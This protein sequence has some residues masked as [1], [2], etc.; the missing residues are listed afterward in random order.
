[1][2]TTFQK[3]FSAGLNRGLSA[4]S[5]NVQAW[6]LTVINPCVKASF[7]FQVV[8]NSRDSSPSVRLK[9]LNGQDHFP[10]ERRSYLQVVRDSIVAS[11][12]AC[13]A[14]DPGSIPGRQLTSVSLECRGHPTLLYQ[15]NG[16]TRSSGLGDRLVPAD[17]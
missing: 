17:E 6:A 1:M 2:W 13:H 16:F 4:S 3:P 15:R 7:G 14:D 9:I 12:S 5:S 11:I 8:A 10:P